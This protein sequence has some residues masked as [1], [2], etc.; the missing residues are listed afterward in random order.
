M[1]QMQEIYGSYKQLR[2]GGIDPKSALSTLRPAIEALPK[3]E[4]DELVMMMRTWESNTVAAAAQPVSAPAPAPSAIKPLRRIKPL[5]SDETLPR[6]SE[7]MDAL[8]PVACPS[9]G[10]LNQPGEALCYHCGGMLDGGRGS[11]ETRHFGDQDNP[12]LNSEFFGPDSVL[13]LRVRGAADTYE[14]QPQRSGHEMIIGRGA[15]GS[16]MMPDID[17]ERRGGA[18]LGVSRMHLGIRYD[19][20]QNAVMVADLNSAN[21]SFLNGQR[22]ISKEVRVLRHGDELRLGKLVLLVSFRHPANH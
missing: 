16:V 4:R 21:G 15:S 2:S 9:C 13:A 20:E 18:D 14:V 3:P 17:L 7:P 12:A 6:P 19:R 8:A 10:K 11:T 22:L 1:S 5:N